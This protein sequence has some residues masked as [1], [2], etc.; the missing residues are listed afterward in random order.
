MSA[1]SLFADVGVG[2]AR[3]AGGHGMA[4]VVEQATHHFLRY[5]VVDQPGGVGYLYFF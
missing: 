1:F 4:G 2:E 5:V 3:V